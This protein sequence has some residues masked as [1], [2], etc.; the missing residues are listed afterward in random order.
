MLRLRTQKMKTTMMWR[1]LGWVNGRFGIGST[2]IFLAKYHSISYNS[3]SS[4]VS[5]W[6]C[7][8]IIIII[9]DE[10]Q[11][12]LT[13][14]TPSIS[15]TNSFCAKENNEFAINN[16]HS[17]SALLYT[18]ISMNTIFLFYFFITSLTHLIMNSRVD[19]FSSL[20][21]NFLSHIT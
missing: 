21:F 17:L 6:K 20:F 19:R 14:F 5:K 11:L 13:L 18:P 9:T 15:F 12:T 7:W 8:E 3:S 16:S 4:F 1:W 10:F 2:E